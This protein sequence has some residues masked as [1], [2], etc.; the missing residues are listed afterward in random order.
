MNY[1]FQSKF[2]KNKGQILTRKNVN[3]QRCAAVNLSSDQK[4]EN[5]LIKKK[6]KLP[7]GICR[8]PLHR[9]ESKQGIDHLE[10]DSVVYK[11]S[12]FI[13]GFKLIENYLG[14]KVNRRSERKKNGKFN[15]TL[16]NIDA[17]G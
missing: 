2:L 10:F 8:P 11:A 1:K 17:L 9:E 4:F 6:K 15:F 3:L 16:K 12:D 7:C 14:F 13:N 5:K